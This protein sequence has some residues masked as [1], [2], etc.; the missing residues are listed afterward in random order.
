MMNRYH[1]GVAMA[2]L[3]EDLNELR[4]RVS[5]FCENEGYELSPQ[6]DAILGDIINMKQLTGDCHCP[7]QSQQ[8]PETI[9]VCQPVRNGLVDVMGACFCNLIIS[10]KGED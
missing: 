1:N 3:E 8:T 5:A 6:A 9:C 7:C 2:V 10:K 4:E